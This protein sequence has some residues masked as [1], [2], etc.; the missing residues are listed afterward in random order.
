MF[1][2]II[3]EYYTMFNISNYLLKELKHAIICKI[4][5]IFLNYANELSLLLNK[6]QDK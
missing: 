6:S 4:R 2:G 1:I 3:Q 5:V